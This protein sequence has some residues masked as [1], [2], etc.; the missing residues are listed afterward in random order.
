MLNSTYFTGFQGCTMHW[1]VFSGG[2]TP[3]S[4]YFLQVCRA[5]ER[6]GLV[7]FQ[8]EMLQVKKTVHCI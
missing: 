5:T 4:G 3:E 7:L 6:I 1:S 8:Y 2:F